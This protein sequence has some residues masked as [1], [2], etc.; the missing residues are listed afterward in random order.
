MFANE[1]VGKLAVRTKAT[2]LGDNSYTTNPVRIVKATESHVVVKFTKE[3]QM[4][5]LVGLT[6][7]THILNYTF[8]DDGWT[9]YEELVGDD[10]QNETKLTQEETS[11]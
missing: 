9:D 7:K 8:C 11:C 3:D 6:S 10:S 1:L 2:R 4:A 5:R